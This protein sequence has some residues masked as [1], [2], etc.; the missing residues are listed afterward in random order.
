M[1]FWCVQA[2]NPG[3]KYIGEGPFTY[4][5][6]KVVYAK[7]SSGVLAALKAAKT[8]LAVLQV[9]GNDMMRTLSRSAV[10]EIYQ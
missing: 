8:T 5:N 3:W 10:L 1:L 2:T 9:R 7:G 4:P 6:S